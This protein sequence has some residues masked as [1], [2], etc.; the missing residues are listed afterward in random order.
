M[1]TNLA[2]YNLSLT[3]SDSDKANI[4]AFLTEK[5]KHPADVFHIVEYP[6]ALEHLEEMAI[7]MAKLA[8][9]SSFD[10][11]GHIDTGYGYIDFSL[12]Y[13]SGTLTSRGGEDG[14]FDAITIQDYYP[15][16]DEFCDRFW[17]DDNDCPLYTEEEYE[18][19]CNWE[20]A[21]ITSDDRILPDEPSMGAPR[22]FRINSD[23]VVL[24]ESTNSWDE[25]DEDWEEDE[26]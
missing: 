11:N 2:S 25:D 1:A 14:E 19:F 15:D 3:A 20:I 22:V 9:Q 6:A 24:E 21:F 13:A 17:D 5:L 18:E 12:E 23:S 16:Y 10:M 26:D 7:E 4:T 8:P